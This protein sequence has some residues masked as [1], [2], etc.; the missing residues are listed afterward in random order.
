MVK[1]RKTRYKIQKL[2]PTGVW[3]KQ[4]EIVP[5]TP[6]CS[7][8]AAVKALSRCVLDGVGYI[9]QQPYEAAQND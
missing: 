8:Y 7:I 2:T 3:A 9:K 5:G 1:N 6:K 4:L